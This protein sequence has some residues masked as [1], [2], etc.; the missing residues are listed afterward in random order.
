VERELRLNKEEYERF[1]VVHNFLLAGERN[2]E[3]DYYNYLN[4]SPII[5]SPL[6]NNSRVNCK[7]NLKI[8]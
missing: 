2:N 3:P 6:W 8:D 1:K 4:N 5:L 7:V